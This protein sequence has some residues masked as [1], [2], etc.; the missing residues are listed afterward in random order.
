MKVSELFEAKSDYVINNSHGSLR[1]KWNTD[2]EGEEHEGYIPDGYDKKVLELQYVEAK[3]LGQGDGE[4]LMKEFLASK[5]AKSAELIFLDPNPH[6]GKFANSTMSEDEQIKKLIRFYKKF[7]FR[8]NPKS[9]R[10]WLVQK[11]TIQDS[12]LPT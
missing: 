3:N 4:A 12:K 9:N 11:G 7:G 8:K 5:I 10:M 2:L 1:A 6:L